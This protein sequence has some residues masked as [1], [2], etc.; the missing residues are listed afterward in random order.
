MAFFYCHNKVTVGF[1]CNPNAKLDLANKAN[2]LGL[3]LSEYV[4]NIVVNSDKLFEIALQQ[5]NEEKAILIK[6]NNEQKEKIDFYE[7]DHLKTL[8]KKY[9]N[10]TVEFTNAN[11]ETIKLKIV[12]IQ[13]VFTIITSSFK[14]EQNEND[15]NSISIS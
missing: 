1:K 9:K 10:Q 12:E 6:T 11:N 14:I 15:S 8:F 13:N 5:E 7:N 2:Q 4:E 3:T